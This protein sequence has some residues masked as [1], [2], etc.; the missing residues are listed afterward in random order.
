MKK[1][2][3]L[4]NFNGSECNRE[5]LDVIVMD[6]NLVADNKCRVWILWNCVVIGTPL[7]DLVEAQMRTVFLSQRGSIIVQLSWLGHI[8]L[9]IVD[10]LI[11]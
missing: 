8:D 6:V 9:R 10:F 4:R 5:M 11:G 1:R 2:M 3:S 7:T